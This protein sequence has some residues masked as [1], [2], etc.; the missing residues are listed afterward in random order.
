MIQEA[1]T[2]VPRACNDLRRGVKAV[3]MNRFIVLVAIAAAAAGC[4]RKK[5]EEALMPPSGEPTVV[6][7][8]SAGSGSAG[9]GSAGS[10]SA[11][12]K[13]ISGEDL[14]KR[15]EQC[16]GYFNDAQ[17]DDFKGCY[18][19]DAVYELPG[20]PFS[21]VT[22]QAAIVDQRK[23]FKT[24]FPDL[25]GEN[26]LELISG[27]TIIGITLVRGTM[28]GPMKTPMGELPPTK[29]KIGLYTSQVI[30]VNDAGQASHEWEIFH[31]GTMQGQM[32]PDPKTPVRP[33]ADKLAMPK[34]V[35]VAKDDDKEKANLAV[36]KKLN[37][38]VSAHDAK[39]IGE[40]LADDAV[41][42]TQ[43]APK[44]R[45]K[46]AVLEHLQD[47]WK[48][49]SDLKVT[50]DKEWAAGDYVATVGALDGTNDGDLPALHIKK[51]GK[52]VHVPFLS[53]AKLDGGKVKTYS[54]FFT[55][56]VVDQLTA[57]AAPPAK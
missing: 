49:I 55:Q 7:S 43:A 22:G 56:T 42:S 35:V 37:A 53:I 19:A 46:K 34:E 18:A 17:W 39:G 51:T 8:G 3:R 9:S 2:R 25:V 10:G 29:N 16:W 1:A 36:V 38:A 26:Q 14:S 4:R 20:G 23:P 52:R 13:S 5:P 15:F 28:Q 30:D 11:A 44:D 47:L 57:P 27:H 32:K 24:T 6:G 54:V 12:A 31:L 33:V 21:P 48:G 45:D 41:W 40:L 50:E